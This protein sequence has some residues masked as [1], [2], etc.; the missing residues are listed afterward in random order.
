MREAG[1]AEARPLREDDE[2]AGLEAAGEPVEI[3]EAGRDAGDLLLPF[4]E[5]L[6]GLEGALHDLAHVREGGVR[7]LLGDREDAPLGV[8]DEFAH[9][10]DLLVPEGRDGVGGLDYA[11]RERLLV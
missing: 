9:R 3:G 2:I 11:A 8:V 1:L 6:D 10:A 4:V 7:L 5:L